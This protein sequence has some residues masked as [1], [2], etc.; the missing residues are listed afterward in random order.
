MFESAFKIQ[1]AVYYIPVFSISPSGLFH[2]IFVYTTWISLN[3]L[4]K[5]FRTYIEQTEY[6]IS[7]SHLIQSFSFFIII[8]FLWF[9]FYFPLNVSFNIYFQFYIMIVCVLIFPFFI[10]FSVQ[11]YE[12]YIFWT[13]ETLKIFK[14]IF[15]RNQL[16]DQRNIS[17]EIFCILYYLYHREE[18]SL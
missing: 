8:I 1:S 7:L 5:L 14:Q 3:V 15:S 18:G 17:D 2:F 4:C 16:T 11:F 12:L 13:A 6:F 9:E 10:F